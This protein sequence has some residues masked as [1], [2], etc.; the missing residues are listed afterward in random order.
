MFQS[1]SSSCA[2]N[3]S[4]F[5]GLFPIPFLCNSIAFPFSTFFNSSNS[6]SF[7][8]LYPHFSFS[9]W[10]RRPHAHD[11]DTNTKQEEYNYGS[12]EATLGV[13]LGNNL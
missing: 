9:Y 13:Q 4:D 2:V 3:G 8:I 1:N 11:I 7:K 12:S 5:L 6:L 10:S